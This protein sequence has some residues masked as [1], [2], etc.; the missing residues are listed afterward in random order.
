M[1]C[2]QLE[3]SPI[4]SDN[5]SARIID[6]PPLSKKFQRPKNNKGEQKKL[7]DISCTNSAYFCSSYPSWGLD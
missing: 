3:S 7:T 6:T 4:I 1:V 5:A 2:L